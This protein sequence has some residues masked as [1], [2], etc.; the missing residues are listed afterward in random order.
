MKGA[1]E[2][3]LSQYVDVVIG[4]SRF[5]QRCWLELLLAV[6]PFGSLSLLNSR[7]APRRWHKPLQRQ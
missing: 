6:T 2:L 7:A 3:S 5:V 1:E 4:R